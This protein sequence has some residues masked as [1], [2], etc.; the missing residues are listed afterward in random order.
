MLVAYYISKNI[1]EMQL[2]WIIQYL[3]NKF[4]LQHLFS[5]RKTQ[6][7]FAPVSLIYL[8]LSRD[9]FK[10]VE[11]HQNMWVF[12]VLYAPRHAM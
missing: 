9:S 3:C 7:K 1:F 6:A 12:C 5:H 8:S 2:E 11:M 4:M 10:T